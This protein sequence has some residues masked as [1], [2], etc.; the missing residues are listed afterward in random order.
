M[1]L[2]EFGPLYERYLYEVH[3]RYILMHPLGRGF[4]TYEFQPDG[5]Y[6]AEVFVPKAFRRTGAAR[7]MLAMV[8]DVARSQ[9]LRR[10]YGTVD[11]T[12]ATW[13]DS[14]AAQ[15]ATGFVL[16]V[17]KDGKALLVKEFA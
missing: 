15:E 17:V 4:M 5:V 1:S 7:A 9:G 3:R 6:I 2:D 11:A 8:E 16:T 10:I 12:T 14:V 13:R